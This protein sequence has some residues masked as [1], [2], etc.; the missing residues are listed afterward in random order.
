[1]H[2]LVIA[3]IFSNGRNKSLRR[4]HFFSYASEDV[5][6]YKSP[7]FHSDINGRGRSFQQICWNIELWAKRIL[8]KY[9]TTLHAPPYLSNKTSLKERSVVDLSYL[10]LKFNI[11][12]IYYSAGL[13]NVSV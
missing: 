7:Q 2:A 8:G 11:Y 6:L 13:S 3:V 4:L 9:P 1:M 12:L 5:K 10:R